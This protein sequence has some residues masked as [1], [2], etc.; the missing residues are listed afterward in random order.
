MGFA[1]AFNDPVERV[2]RFRGEGYP[3]GND[4]LVAEFCFDLFVPTDEISRS[5]EDKLLIRL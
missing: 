3:E 2:G 5:L 4:G 1:L